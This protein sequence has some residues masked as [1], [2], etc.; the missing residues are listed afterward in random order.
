MPATSTL[1]RSPSSGRAG[2]GT[3][4][5]SKGAT[6]SSLRASPPRTVTKLGQNPSAQVKSLLQ[7][8][9]LMRRL[10]PHSVSSG[11]IAMQLETLPQSPQPFADLGVDVGADFRIGQLAALPEPPAL[12]R[13]GL[14]VEDDRDALVLAEIALRLVH[15]VAM[16]KAD[17]G[18]QRDAEIAAGIVD[19]QRHLPDA[20]GGE[21]GED[22]RRRHAAFDRLAAGH[23]DEAV[24]EDLV[25]DRH[26]R[27]DRLP[28]RQHAGM[29]VGAV[30]E[31]GEHMAL[32]W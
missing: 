17:A 13:A 6:L 25:G 3:G 14:V 12:G 32:A 29:G 2:S 27:R 10:R 26:A 28:D 23:R 20:L 19:D 30:A 22:L 5:R 16:A 7:L 8:D 15:R 1:Y 11:S 18:R 31:I 24:V 9:W 21:L 4:G